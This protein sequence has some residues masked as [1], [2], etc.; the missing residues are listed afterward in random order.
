MSA[1][2]LLG[3]CLV[4]GLAA[5]VQSTVGFGLALIAIPP[6]VL[7]DPGLVPGPFLLASLL[8]GLLMVWREAGAVELRTLAIP[9]L[10]LFAGTGA[11][12]AALLVIPAG[13]L[14]QIFGILILLAIA[15]SA[16]GLRVR[17]NAASLFTAGG[18]GGLI[19]TMAGV[20]GP[21]MVLLMQSRPGPHIR[22]TM[23]AFFVA[24]YAISLL[25]LAAVGLFG[26]EELLLG[27][28]LCPGILLGWL[29]A[30]VLIRRVDQQRLRPLILWLATVAALSLLVVG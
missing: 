2:G 11:G 28:A 5:A 12:A 16:S 1:L 17:V 21:P 6:L 22:A 20:H 24:G 14:P 15:A 18:L 23:G 30:P 29:V 7:I 13:H 10:G 9:I 27:L 19:G 26:L 4:I 8:L 3:G 25:G